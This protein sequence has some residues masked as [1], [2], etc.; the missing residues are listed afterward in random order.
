MGFAR[1]INF[2]YFNGKLSFESLYLNKTLG[3]EDWIT[4]YRCLKKMK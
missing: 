1:V 4:Y 2:N 3:L